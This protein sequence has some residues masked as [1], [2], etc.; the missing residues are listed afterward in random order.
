MAHLAL[1]NSELHVDYELGEPSHGEHNR[2]SQAVTLPPGTGILYPGPNAIPLSELPP[3]ARP[4]TLV[5]LDGTWHHAH[6]LYRDC[7]WLH[8]LPCYTLQPKE[9]SRYRIRKEPAEHCLS[10]V[11]AI[12]SALGTL[13][14]ALPGLS[15]LL[16]SFDHMIDAQ[17]EQ[18]QQ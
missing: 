3:E 13:E 14:P 15:E 7:K 11:E 2:L 17:I 8:Q 4:Q 10:T 6:Y 16:T 1:L 12:V 18:R 5:V 9:P